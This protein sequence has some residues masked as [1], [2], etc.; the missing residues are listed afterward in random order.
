LKIKQLQSE[1]DTEVGKIG[2][3]AN[4]MRGKDKVCRYLH[5]P[6]PR[7]FSVWVRQ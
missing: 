6:L 1:S 2:Q 5:D 4:A 7:D 3:E